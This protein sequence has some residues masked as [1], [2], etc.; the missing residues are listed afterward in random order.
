[1]PELETMDAFFTARLE[2]YDEHMLEAVEGCREGYEAMAAR[3]PA[4]THTLLDLG[5]G[6]GLELD[7]IFRRLPD[8]SVTGID[9]TASMLGRLREKHPDKDLTL[10]CGDYFQTDFGLSRYDCA[11][12]FETMHH[13]RP[14]DKL[15]LY[16]RLCAAIKDG[17]MYLE[18]DY[19][20]GTQIEEDHHFAVYE[21]LRR[22]E[23]IPEGVFCHYDTP[24]TVERQISL[25]LE[26]GFS[27]VEKVFSLGNTVML[28]AKK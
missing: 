9:L 3:I 21:Q 1:M 25:L 13:F 17:G 18:C 4:G 20:V 23:Q 6:T 27:S 19:M 7:A 15:G 28:A 14:A 5:C 22:A 8:L 10:I 11:V 26:A 12:S 2:G 24:C 16:K